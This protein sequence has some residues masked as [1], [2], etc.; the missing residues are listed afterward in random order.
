[1]IADSQAEAAND[2][3]RDKAGEYAQARANRI[4][5]TEFRKSKKAMLMNEKQG[6]PEHVR[7]SYAYAHKDYLEILEGI[8]EATYI[9][10]KLRWQM[11]AAQARIDIWRTQSSNKRGGF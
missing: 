3:I 8:K 6:E 2:F 11:V 4:Q 9:E 5:L 10:E 1:M 7:T